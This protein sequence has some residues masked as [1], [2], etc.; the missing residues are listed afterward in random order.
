MD[1][2]TIL[3]RLDTKER[4]IGRLSRRLGRARFWL[5]G[6]EAKLGMSA[7]DF[8][9]L[10]G[11]K[12]AAV[13]GPDGGGVA[14]GV[15]ALHVDSRVDQALHDA[16]KKLDDALERCHAM[17]KQ[18][19]ELRTLTG[20][21]EGQELE[22]RVRELVRDAETLGNL[23]VSRREELDRVR[24]ERDDALDRHKQAHDR[25]QALHVV[26]DHAVHELRKVH[27]EQSVSY[28]RI[29]AHN[30][31]NILVND[32]RVK[33]AAAEVEALRAQ[34]ADVHP[35]E[36]MHR[37]REAAGCREGQTLLERIEV[38]VANAANWEAEAKER[39]DVVEGCH[40]LE[41]RMAEA[42]KLLD[43][44]LEV[45]S[46]EGW[47][48]VR[49]ALAILARG[50]DPDPT[51]AEVWEK[52][53]RG[54]DGRINQAVEQL[55]KTG[56][57]VR[58]DDGATRRIVE[59]AINILVNEDNV[60]TKPNSAAT[61][62]TLLDQIRLKL[63]AA[64]SGSILPVIEALQAQKD[65]DR[66]L[67]V[68]RREELDRVRKERDEAWERLVEIGNA[69]Q[70]ERGKEDMVEK[71][72][73]LASRLEELRKE[74]NEQHDTYEE[75]LKRVA[76]ERDSWEKAAHALNGRIDQAVEYL[77]RSPRNASDID[78]A[79][80]LLTSDEAAG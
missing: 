19:S 21:A 8:L 3:D 47:R 18:R 51:S 16:R 57:I 77:N 56:D 36:D 41:N 43:G 70:L 2:K 17:A 65:A 9:E 14:S 67:L 15:N 60:L 64:T 44:A 10:D 38:L 7:R 78:A 55:R 50:E 24:G 23:L 72:A 46:I 75:S 29:F 33:E 34:C 61:S 80:S 1:D 26:I 73:G 28:N 20:C 68:S 79:I 74:G 35:A 25:A 66:R 63:G 59:D 45:D 6:V 53:A 52:V 12:A 27:S 32:E 58:H 69:I 30:A 76:G 71:V 37:W 54:L 62:W 40:R 39:N 49:Q 4:T 22:D 31:I 11:T 13:T 5:N 48:K 42:A